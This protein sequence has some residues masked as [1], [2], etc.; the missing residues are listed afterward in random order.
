[1]VPT[2]ENGTVVQ[3]YFL[4]KKEHLK[5]PATVSLRN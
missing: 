3:F 4:F 1:M 5:A 2:S